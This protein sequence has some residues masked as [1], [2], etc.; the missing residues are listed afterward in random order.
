[1]KKKQT[2][3]MIPLSVVK[4]VFAGESVKLTKELFAA[5][6]AYEEARAA[7][8]DARLALVRARTRLEM[9]DELSDENTKGPA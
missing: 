2:D 8:R 7:E 3:M 9:F 4:H 1:M 5:Q 6:K